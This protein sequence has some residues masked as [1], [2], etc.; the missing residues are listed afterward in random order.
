MNEILN[1]LKERK[2]KQIRNL[3]MI[4]S[5]ILSTVSAYAQQVTVSGTVSSED[6]PLPGASSSS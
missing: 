6:G 4:F 2:S 1:L 3:V 5:L